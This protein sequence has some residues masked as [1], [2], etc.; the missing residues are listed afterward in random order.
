MMLTICKYDVVK[1]EK[2]P[3]KYKILSFICG[4]NHRNHYHFLECLMEFDFWS[5]KKYL[6]NWCS[7][8]G[9]K[10]HT[11]DYTAYEPAIGVAFEGKMYSAPASPKNV[12]SLIYGDDYMQMPPIEKRVTHNPLRLSFD[13][14][15]EDVEL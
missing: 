12:L 4:K 14:S 13:L 8:Y 5:S 9:Y 1:Q 7:P 11:F 2:I 3:L 15:K 6:V 10:K